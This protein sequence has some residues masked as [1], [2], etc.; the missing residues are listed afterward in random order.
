MVNILI[1]AK[2]VPTSAV[3]PRIAESAESIHEA[4]LSFEINEADLYAIEEGVYQ[5][6]VHGG[7]LIAATIGPARAR[8]VFPVAF[9]KGADQ[10]VHVVDEARSGK[11]LSAN[12]LAAKKIVDR[13][14]PQLILCGVQASD[15][16]QGHFGIMLA[17]ALGYPCV[18]AVIEINVDKSKRTATVVRETGAGFKEQLELD[19]PCLLTVQFGIRPLKYTPIMSVVRM[20]S[21]PVD[22]VTY[23]D[24]VAV[25][26]D[27]SLTF[28][29]RI[30]EFRYPE[31]GGKCQI[32][33]GS[34]A[35][36]A[37]ELMK[38]LCDRGVF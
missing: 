12:V 30:V 2:H 19:L 17:E 36:A 24:L 34:P 27:R 29:T 33:D 14:A 8:E 9:A 5:K 35:Q 20:R 6:S 10:A 21:R 23:E 32:F 7:S 25:L 31:A 26:D 15:D 13:C 3:R 28:D 4:G 37:D 18:T 38:K 11:A 16:M 1:F 22:S